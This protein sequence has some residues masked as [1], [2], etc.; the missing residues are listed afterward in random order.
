[1]IV[2]AMV[3]VC[4]RVAD[5]LRRNAI[6][7]R[8]FFDDHA[9]PIFRNMVVIHEDYMKAF[10]KG[11]STYAKNMDATFVIIPQ[12]GHELITLTG[13]IQGDPDLSYLQAIDGIGREDLFYGYHNDDE[14]SPFTF[15][16]ETSFY[17]EKARLNGVKILVTDYCSTPSK[18]DDSY[19]T[20]ADSG[21]I[22]FAADPA[23]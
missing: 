7:R 22:S 23:R 13:K 11:I 6:A 16:S 4:D 5:L 1:M 2:E 21:Y 3:E 12:N 9:E 20:C 8:Q 18:M 10:A 15:S 14:K 19:A 17:L